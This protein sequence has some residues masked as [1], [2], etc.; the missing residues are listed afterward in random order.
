[1]MTKFKF[2]IIPNSSFAW[3]G[4]WLSQV[5]EKIVIAPKIG[6]VYIIMIKLI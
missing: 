1:M 2:Y 5:D 6:A 3:W 4:A